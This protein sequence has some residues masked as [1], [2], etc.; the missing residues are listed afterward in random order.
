MQRF[1]GLL[2]EVEWTDESN[3]T[4]EREKQRTPPTCRKKQEALQHIKERVRTEMEKESIRSG[5]GLDRKLQWGDTKK[6]NLN[7]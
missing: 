6:K 3:P 2:Q 4:E 7:Q 1:A 5:L